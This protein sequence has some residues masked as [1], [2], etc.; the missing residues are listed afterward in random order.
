MEG[1][2]YLFYVCVSCL[3]ALFFKPKIMKLNKKIFSMCFKS[4]IKRIFILKVFQGGGAWPA[5]LLR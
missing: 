5:S 4:K 3:E 1:V 2:S